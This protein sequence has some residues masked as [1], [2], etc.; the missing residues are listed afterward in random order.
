MAN[1]KYIVELSNEERAHL[2]AMISKGKCSAQANLKAR[3][4]LK[5]DQG[6]D[7]DGACDTA[8]CEALDTNVRMVE[9]VRAKFVTEG[10]EAV[11]KRKQRE[12][13]PRQP[14]FDGEAEARLCATS[15]R[16]NA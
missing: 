7:G 14:I 16:M 8:I 13:P 6:A 11:F 5:A 15:F 9:R 3:I 2:G 10:L 4:L 1:K 12:T